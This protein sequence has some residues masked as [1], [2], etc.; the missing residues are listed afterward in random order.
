[1]SAS[2]L[3]CSARLFDDEAG[4]TLKV[5]GATVLVAANA[6]HVVQ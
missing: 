3:F 1:M 4:G 6:E 2:P 5:I